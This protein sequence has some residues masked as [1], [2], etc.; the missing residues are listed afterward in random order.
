MRPAAPR[1]WAVVGLHR[2]EDHPVGVDVQLPFTALPG[3]GQGFGGAVAVEHRRVEGPFDA[4]AHRQGERFAAGGEG[5]S[6]GAFAGGAVGGAVD[7]YYSELR[8]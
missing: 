3:D 2:F 6:E 7:Y 1:R 5:D 4:L 8:Q